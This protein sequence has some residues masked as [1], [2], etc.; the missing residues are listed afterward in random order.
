MDPDGDLYSNSRLPG[1]CASG[2]WR[3]G[4]HTGWES[5]VEGGDIVALMPPMSPLMSQSDKMSCWITGT[6][7][8]A[9]CGGETS[10]L[11]AEGD[12]YKINGGRHWM[13]DEPDIRQGPLRR[14][15]YRVLDI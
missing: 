1:Q 12:I 14:P 7:E 15:C 13:P 11:C 10:P 6:A 2:I 8:L 9:K 3:G 5:L 4:L